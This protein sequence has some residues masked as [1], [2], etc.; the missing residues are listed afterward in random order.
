VPGAVPAHEYGHRHFNADVNGEPASRLRETAAPPVEPKRDGHWRITLGGARQEIMAPS[1]EWI[2]DSVQ[3]EGFVSL[4]R[5]LGD[6]IPVVR[7]L[8]ARVGLNFSQH[9]GDFVGV[10]FSELEIGASYHFPHDGLFDI[11]FPYA[12]LD[13]LAA[14]AMVETGGGLEDDIF[15]P[16]FGV[17]I[18]TRVMLPRMGR[19]QNVRLFGLVE[20][21][22][23][24]RV[25][26]VPRLTL[27]PTHEDP[28]PEPPIPLGQLSMLGFN[29]RLGVGLEF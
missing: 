26:V 16:G 6:L 27:P 4:E 9:V 14:W 7:G 12:H 19:S 25:S 11:I 18:G 20:G 23:Q 5:N 1:N 24:L 17:S 8:G 15:V 22:W 29:L 3:A 13:F 2:G 28:E 21:G 10:Y